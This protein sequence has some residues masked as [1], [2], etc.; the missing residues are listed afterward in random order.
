LVSLTGGKK[1]NIKTCYTY[2]P[3]RKLNSFTLFTTA[4]AAA[5]F[6]QSKRGLSTVHGNP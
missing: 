1:S 4:F 6:A 2:L 3:H 5:R